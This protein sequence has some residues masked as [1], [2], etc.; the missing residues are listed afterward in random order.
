MTREEYESLQPTYDPGPRVELTDRTTLLR[1]MAVEE[2]ILFLRAFEKRVPENARFLDVGCGAGGYLLA[3]AGLGW[4]ATGIEPSDTHSAVG[5]AL[6]LDI[7]R[8]YFDASSLS[9]GSYDFVLLSHVI[10]HIYH[11]RAFIDGLMKVTR[12]G[13]LLVVITPNVESFASVL[14]GA[15]WAMYKPIDH[16]SMFGPSALKY[17]TPSGIAM[18]WYTSEYPGEILISSLIAIRDAIMRLS[19]KERGKIIDDVNTRRAQW[20]RRELRG[21]ALVALQR[22][23]TPLH[24]LAKRTERQACL[25]VEMR[26]PEL[27]NL[28]KSPST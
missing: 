14:A 2:K 19:G 27:G 28:C 26:K 25:I 10:E 22:F 7:R 15:N 23:A 3:A 6:G 5:R 9:C 8:G 1:L 12:P 16:V 17:V 13:G 4:R 11:P 21:R 18:T 24:L 20:Q